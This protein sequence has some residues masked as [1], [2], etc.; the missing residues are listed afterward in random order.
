MKGCAAQKSVNENYMCCEK[1]VKQVG[2]A[3]WKN[4]VDVRKVSKNITP[5]GNPALNINLCVMFVN[6]HRIS[7]RRKP[8]CFA[9]VTVCCKSHRH[10]AY[11]CC[12]RKLY[13]AAIK[14]TV[15]L[16]SSKYLGALIIAT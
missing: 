9:E 13:S 8:A 14:V 12:H 3:K 4:A 5:T 11:L 7:E 16:V 10:L 15:I 6:L 1:E 2:K